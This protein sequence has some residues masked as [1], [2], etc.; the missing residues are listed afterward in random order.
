MKDILN[1]IIQWIKNL[2]LSANR[3][4]EDRRKKE[5]EV[6]INYLALKL[7]QELCELLYRV[8]P[9]QLLPL[10]DYSS[11]EI[12]NWYTNNNAIIV[13]FS[14]DKESNFPS[15]TH[16]EYFK[17]KANQSIFRQR[18]KMQSRNISNVN[19]ELLYNR[20]YEIKQIIE[21]DFNIILTVAVY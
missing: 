16:L 21:C 17:N 8:R 15:G 9:K 3:K 13:R 5:Q 11:L 7:Q 2:F 14:W 4:Y 1:L 18:A 10:V 20:G 19:F 6:K 12:I